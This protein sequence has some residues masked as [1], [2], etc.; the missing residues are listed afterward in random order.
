MR[1]T[2][3]YHA[4]TNPIVEKAAIVR[5]AARN[6][7]ANSL[8]SVAPAARCAWK[9][10][11][12]PANMAIAIRRIGSSLRNGDIDEQYD[13]STMSPVCSNDLRANSLTRIWD[14]H[15]SVAQTENERLSLCLSIR[16]SYSEIECCR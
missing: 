2:G 12:R 13:G 5:N 3:V 7:S 11:A 6:A 4:S 9:D 8:R 16:S 14:S 10:S 15:S 1:R